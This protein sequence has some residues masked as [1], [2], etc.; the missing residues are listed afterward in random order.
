MASETFAYNHLN[1]CFNE[2]KNTEKT[3]WISSQYGRDQF[4]SRLRENPN[5]A[6]GLGDGRT[7]DLL[8]L[9]PTNAELERS[10]L[11]G[12]IVKALALPGCVSTRMKEISFLGNSLS[13]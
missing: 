5:M 6:L 10:L 9:N 11:I 1:V 2:N 3:F 12:S 13:S 7:C 8:E 4:G